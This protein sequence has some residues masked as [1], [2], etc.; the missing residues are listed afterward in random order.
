VLLDVPGEAAGG[1]GSLVVASDGDMTVAFLVEEIGEV[2]TLSRAEFKPVQAAQA[3]G[4]ASH[5]QG[6]LAD[7]TVL[8]D[9]AAILKDPAL[10]I[11]EIVA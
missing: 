6:V 5:L 2:M 3:S 4:L 9:V 8:L 10:E 7:G 11:D 1:A